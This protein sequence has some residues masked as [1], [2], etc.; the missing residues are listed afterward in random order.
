V[1]WC[2]EMVDMGHGLELI[3]QKENV[4]QICQSR[5]NPFKD[6]FPRKSWWAGFKKRHPYLVLRITKGLDR[7]KALN[8]FLAIVSKFYDTLSN[9]YQK[10]S[11][12]SDHIWNSDE[13]KLQVGRNCGIQVIARRGSRLLFYV[14]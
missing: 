11:Y 14:A 6:G 13:T 3:Q 8:C 1:V 7:D 9:A 4:A 2:K 5:P 10:H 12:S